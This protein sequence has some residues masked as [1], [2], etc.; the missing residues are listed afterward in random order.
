MVV[1]PGGTCIDGLRL[2]FRQVPWGD[3]FDSSPGGFIVDGDLDVKGNVVNGEQDFGPSLMVLGT[4]RAHNLG[5]GGALVF[6][7]KDLA[8]RECLHGYYNHGGLMV[9]GDLHARLMVVSEYFGSVEGAFAAPLYGSDH[10]K[11][12]P[13]PPSPP[14]TQLL[15]PEV[16]TA[17]EVEEDDGTLITEWQPDHGALF[18]ALESGLPVVV[19]G[20]AVT[21]C[22]LRGK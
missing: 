7:G 8:V 4:L 14:I 3:G 1:V 10:L 5:L 17:E 16:L 15:I 2:D 6:V 13:R 22:R 9:K 11:T 20:E 21:P 12:G 18:K 19:G